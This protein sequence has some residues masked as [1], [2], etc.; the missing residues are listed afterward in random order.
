MSKY[1]SALLAPPAML[2]SLDLVIGERIL[3]CDLDWLAKQRAIPSAS[4]AHCLHLAAGDEAHAV[5]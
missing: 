4:I 3:S 2:L 5:R 1:E